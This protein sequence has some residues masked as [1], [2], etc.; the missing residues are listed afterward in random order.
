[1]SLAHHGVLF[2]D[3]APEFERRA[4][5]VL[6]QPLEDGWVAVTRVARTARFPA[7][8]L[9]VAAMNPC[10]CGFLGDER[11]ACRCT[12]EQVR[13]YQGRLSGPI[14]DRLDLAVD[15]PAVP[16]EALTDGPPGEATAEVATRVRLAR[17]RQRARYGEHGPR[18]NA[19]VQGR[20]VIAHCTPAPE[21][22]RLLRQASVRLG[23]TARG[24]HRAL[25][26][27]RTIADLD[28]AERVER[29]H[30]AEALQFR[31]LSCGSG[32]TSGGPPCT[33]DETFSTW[34]PAPPS[35]RR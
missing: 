6:R 1:V 22:L 30:V 3:E 2:L 8:V 24:F 16:P 15:V 14:R 5:E 25:R 19:A 13:R 21:A 20:T 18:T 32:A 23:L 33:P 12:P 31:Q 10:P 4:L 7:R 27:A 9:L 11:R 34:R 35:P 17:D 29:A 28:A 26:V